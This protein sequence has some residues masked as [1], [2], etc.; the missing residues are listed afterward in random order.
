MC[1]CVRWLSVC[2]THE[3]RDV[4][5]DV[6][7]S[8]AQRSAKSRRVSSHSSGSNVCQMLPGFAIRTPPPPPSNTNTCTIFYTYRG[9]ARSLAGASAYTCFPFDVAIVSIGGN[10]AHFVTHRMAHG[11][12]RWK[13]GE[14]CRWSSVTRV[15]TRAHKH[16]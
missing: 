12:I 14:L 2:V 10:Y 3:M 13:I 9:L 4:D 6:Q 5:D 8:Q 11:A 7:A 16:L 15:D 1:V